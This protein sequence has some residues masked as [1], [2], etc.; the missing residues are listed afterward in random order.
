MK[1]GMVKWVVDTPMI[2]PSSGGRYSSQYASYWN[3]F[4][5]TRSLDPNFFLANKHCDLK[6]VTR[7][8]KE[9]KDK[10][11]KSEIAK[12]ETNKSVSSWCVHTD[13]TE[14]D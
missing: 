3:A 4:L 7:W 8:Y 2:L 10:I 11:S 9:S 6:H 13:D 5:L 14:S 1:R 12:S